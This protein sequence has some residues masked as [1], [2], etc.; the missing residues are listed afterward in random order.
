VTKKRLRI[1]CGR[2][3]PESPPCIEPRRHSGRRQIDIEFLSQRF[4]PFVQRRQR[5][6]EHLA[7]FQTRQRR[8]I[9]PH[10]L[11][12]LRQGQSLAFPHRFEAR[13]Q[14]QNRRETLPINRASRPLVDRLRR[15]LSANRFF[16]AALLGAAR[17]LDR[18][19]YGF[20][21]WVRERRRR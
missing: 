6:V 5:G 8:R 3:R 20:T 11:R 12:H 13:Q 9:D 21:P 14:P 16:L 2:K 19:F 15:V 4:R 7:R 17:G 1:L 10:A 18:W